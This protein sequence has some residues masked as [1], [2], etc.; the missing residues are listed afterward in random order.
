MN[1]VQ[2]PQTI[3]DTTSILSPLTPNKL[4]EMK[5][6]ELPFDKKISGSGTKS[7]KTEK[8]LPMIGKSTSIV[9]TNNEK[10]QKNSAS[11]IGRGSLPASSQVL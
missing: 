4:N 9:F 8:T 1:F 7:Y 2:N 11:V 10:L 5:K 6:F 3:N